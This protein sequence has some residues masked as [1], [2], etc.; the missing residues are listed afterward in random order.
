MRLRLLRLLGLQ[1]QLLPTSGAA[2]GVELVESSLSAGTSCSGAPQ[3]KVVEGRCVD[4]VISVLLLVAIAVP[5]ITVIVVVATE[6]QTSPSQRGWLILGF[7]FYIVAGLRYLGSRLMELCAQI[8]Y[9]RVEVRRFAAPTLFEAITDAVAAEAEKM[10]VTCSFDQEAVQEHDKLTGRIAVKFRFWSSQTRKVEIAIGNKSEEQGLSCEQLKIQVC[11][12]PGEDVVFGRDSRLERREILV[13]S[14]RTSPSQ[15]LADKKLLIEWMEGSYNNFVKPVKDV[16]NIYAL[17]E[18]S[19][20][21]VP[22]WKFERV[23]PCKSASSTGQGF[24]LERESLGKVLADAKLWSTSALRVYMITGPPGVGKSEFTIWIAGQLGLP[25]YRLSLTSRQLTDERLAQLL[26]QSSVTFNSV[27]VQVDEF[28]E[29]VQRWMTGA[30]VGVTPGGFCEVLQGSTAMSKG[31]VILTGTGHIAAESVKCKLPAVF[32]RIHCIAELSWMSR[33]DIGCYFRQFL[34]RFVPGCS[35]EEWSRWEAR[36]L[37]GSCW[38]GSRP[39]SI[40]MLKQF[41]MHQITESSCQ[42]HGDFVDAGAGSD[43]AVFQVS[44]EQRSS[45]FSLVC[46]AQAAQS[47]LDCYAPVHLEA[48]LEADEPSIGNA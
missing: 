39:I 11:F 16:V 7:G 9:L 17:Q 13:L 25:V 31:V 32:R 14:V 24:F 4:Y 40:D 3:V 43:A 21:W 27:L 46:D 48:H 20:D 33:D 6:W 1:E 35:A 10:G 22:E 12:Q 34:A 47:F 38:S 8:L 29:T 45:F 41:L 28:Q 44:P 23:K 19:S 30:S 15:V 36:F 2:R 26:S 5:S 42:G 37:E 18:S